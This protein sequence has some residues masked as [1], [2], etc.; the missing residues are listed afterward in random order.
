MVIGS[1]AW[2]ALWRAMISAAS[3]S[4]GTYCS[5]SMKRTI[6]V[7]FS[8]AASPTAARSSLRSLSRSPL[9]ARPFSA[10]RSI[11]TWRS[12]YLELQTRNE[13]GKAALSALR[14]AALSASPRSSCMSEAR[15]RRRWSSAGRDRPSGAPMWTP[16]DPPRL[17]VQAD[18]VQENRLADAAQA[19]ENQAA[20]GAMRANA[21]SSAT[22]A[23]SIAARRAQPA[24]AAAFSAPGAYG[25]VL[26][27]IYS[28][29]ILVYLFFDNLE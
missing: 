7:F 23:C 26:G 8:A 4:S 3:C 27:S 9:S 6:A 28:N 13:A 15:Q 12:W 11:P 14:L 29:L 10:V 18:A 25:L 2:L 16:D 20:G 22:A 5:S 1:C 21:G 19:V 24:P 17:G